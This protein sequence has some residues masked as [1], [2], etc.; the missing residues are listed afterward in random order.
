MNWYRVIK[1]ADEIGHG[2]TL[3]GQFMGRE[4]QRIAKEID[5][6]RTIAAAGGPESV[7]PRWKGSVR[8]QI[9]LLPAVAVMDRMSFMELQ[10]VSAK[11]E[12]VHQAME[13]YS[14][15]RFKEI[16]DAGNPR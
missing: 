16:V 10:Q 5:K 11:I 7:L 2:D 8:Q 15:S 6:L 14:V 9:L 3:E 1:T 12:A 13:R 4:K